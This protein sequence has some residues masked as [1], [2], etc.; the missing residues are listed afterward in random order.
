MSIFKSKISIINTGK[1]DK[2]TKAPVM[3]IDTRELYDDI[4]QFVKKEKKRLGVEKL[5]RGNKLQH[6][7]NS[8]SAGY[9]APTSMKSFLACPAGYL[10]NKLTPEPEKVGSAA[11]KGHVFHDIMEKFYDEKVTPIEERTK[12]TLDKI[13][14]K[15][16]VEAKY[17]EYKDEKSPADIKR[18]VENYWNGPDYFEKGKTNGEVAKD[19]MCEVELFEKAVINPLD[20]ASFTEN[21]ESPIPT[22]YTKIDRVDFREKVDPSTGEV[23]SDIFIIDYKTGDGDPDEYSLSKFGYLHQMM[24]YKWIIDSKFGC[25]VKGENIF[26]C[27]PGA[28][29]LDK[30]LYTKVDNCSSLVEQSKLIDYSVNYIKY[31]K[32]V[33][34]KRIFEMKKQKYCSSCAL[35]YQCKAYINS[36]KNPSPDVYKPFVGD[37]VLDIVL[38]IEDEE[39]TEKVAKDADNKI[40]ESKTK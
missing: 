25:D 18:W 39:P 5:D 38:E 13:V 22:V 8:T 16:I 14:K 21:G 31:A 27:I 29:N 1:V 23:I 6:V 28:D 32:N 30:Y 17:A 7:L 24:F 11:N 12:E 20:I 19:I 33:R 15:A 35:K 10:Y 37:E 4:E 40:A 36:L 34:K 3:A 26:L 9:I 2:W